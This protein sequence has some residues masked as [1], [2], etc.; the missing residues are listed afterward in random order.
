MWWFK[1]VSDY[2]FPGRRCPHICEGSPLVAYKWSPNQCEK[3]VVNANQV[4][5]F[6]I[7]CK[8]LCTQ[9]VWLDPEFQF[10]A[11]TIMSMATKS[12]DLE[13]QTSGANLQMEGHVGMPSQSWKEPE[14]TGALGSSPSHSPSWSPARRLPLSHPN[15]RHCLGIPMTLTKETGAV[16][17]LPHALAVHLVED[18]ICYARTGLTKAIVMGPGRAILFYGRWSL[19]EDLSLDKARDAAFI[20]TGVGT[21]VGKPAYLAA[22]SLTIQEG[23]WAITQAITECQIKVRGQGIC[24]WICW[25]H[26]HSDFTIWEILPKRTPLEMPILTINYWPTGLQEAGTAIIIKRLPPPQL[27]SP[28]PDCGFKSDSSLLSMASLMSSLS[29]RLEGSQHSQCG[30]WCRETGTRMKINLPIFKHED[31]K[32][33]VT[34]QSWRWDLM[35]YPYAIWSLQGYPCY[36]RQCWPIVLYG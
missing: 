14:E 15:T 19:G 3:D 35:V 9:F 5:F 20:L 25:P 11:S 8:G 22:D 18:M 6:F 7:S 30:R 21:W 27:P 17:P 32:D 10:T 24:V 29:D 4:V 34:Y 28:S 23:Q 2:L 36:V 33:A 12:S 16:P 1:E 13:D 26:N 31:A